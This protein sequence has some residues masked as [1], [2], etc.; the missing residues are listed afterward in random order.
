MRF[1]TAH[2]KKPVRPVV[3]TPAALASR[4]N[5]STIRQPP[6]GGTPAMPLTPGRGS[7]AIGGRFGAAV[8]M[9]RGAG[10]MPPGVSAAFAAGIRVTS[11]WARTILTMVDAEY[12]AA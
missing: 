11:N 3:S 9:L 12:T 5:P 6:T 1:V 10:S 2:S 8:V 4:E 7:L